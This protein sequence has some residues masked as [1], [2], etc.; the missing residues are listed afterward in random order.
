MQGAAG[1]IRRLSRAL[2]TLQPQGPASTGG[3]RL[4]AQ[5]KRLWGRLGPGTQGGCWAVLHPARGCRLDASPGSRQGGQGS[6]RLAA[7]GLAQG[8]VSSL[9]SA[10]P[11]FLQ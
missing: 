8:D 10:M 9:D 7:G 6:L 5:P 1:F 4:G 11:T 2:L 3:H